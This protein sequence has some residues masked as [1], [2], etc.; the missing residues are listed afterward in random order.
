MAEE[1]GAGACSGRQAKSALTPVF[2]TRL[3]SLAVNRS[4]RASS[5][6][7]AGQEQEAAREQT[8]T[9]SVNQGRRRR[10]C[11][12]TSAEGRPVAR[13]GM[14]HAA[15]AAC[16]PVPWQQLKAGGKASSVERSCPVVCLVRCG[17]RP[18]VRR[19]PRRRARE[20]LVALLTLASLASARHDSTRLD[21]ALLGSAGTGAGEESRVTLARRSTLR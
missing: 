4:E 14:W 21:S 6:R 10:K 8:R 11:V 16:L 1:C 2:G 9:E 15:R 18:G 17:E 13:D 12:V 3:S 19:V 5:R 20:Q 7:G